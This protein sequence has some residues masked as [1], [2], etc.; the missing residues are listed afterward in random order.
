[1]GRSFFSGRSL[2]DMRRERRGALTHSFVAP[3]HEVGRNYPGG[4]QLELLVCQQVPEKDMR[5]EGMV[6][7]VGM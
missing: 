5:V 2:D 1:M 3:S 6:G 4:D 7:A